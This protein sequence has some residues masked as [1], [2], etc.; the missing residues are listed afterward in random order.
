MSRG[1]GIAFCRVPSHC[2][3]YWNKISE[4]S[5][6][7]RAVK[8]LSEISCNNLLLSSHEISSVLEN[9]MYTELEKSKSVI[10]SCSKYLAGVI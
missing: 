7:Q 9:T 10:P 3:L 6:I 2:G 1:I 8:N 5:S 4:R